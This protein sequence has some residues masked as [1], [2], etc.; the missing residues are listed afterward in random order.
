M[1]DNINESVKLCTCQSNLSCGVLLSNAQ[2]I[3]GMTV[4][5]LVLWLVKLIYIFFGQ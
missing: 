1:C 2:I 3:C 4:L 5:V